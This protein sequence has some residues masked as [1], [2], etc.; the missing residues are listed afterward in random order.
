MSNR[1]YFFAGGGT[2][3]HIYP[4]LATAQQLREIDP[5]GE[6]HFFCS[7]RP[8]DSQ[9]LSKTDFAF[10]PL[11]AKGF[12]VRP[13]QLIAFLNSIRKSRAIVKPI[14]TQTTDNTVVIGVGGFASAPVVLTANKLGLPV[15]MI[16]V[17]I[18]PGKANKF[19]ARYASKIF[20]QFDDTAKHFGK[21]SP[22]VETTGCPLRK[23]FANPNPDKVYDDLKLDRSKRTLL[24]TGAST[25]AQN[26]NDAILTILPALNEF[27][28]NW[29]IV[30]LTGKANFQSVTNAYQTKRCQ[31]PFILDYYDNM[32]DL[33]AA[34]DILIGRAGAVSIAEFAASA[35]PAI[36]LPY[37]YHKDKHQYLNAQQLVNAG[38]A[39]IVDD[40]PGNKQKTAQML[41]TQLRE[42]MASDAK[43]KAMAKAASSVHRIDAASCIACKLADLKI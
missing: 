35:T 11:P 19:L 4:A 29:Q 37:P 34:A 2:G 18:V 8:I 14:L 15:A 17:D 43:R 42:L 32:W 10:T 20:V 28:E 40:L 27:A 13:A 3:G 23:G 1:R 39:V 21:N 33:Y 5:E 41:L 16:N 12:S 38:A 6:I 25:G 31:E 7:D 26:I 9:I 36:C 22:K 24:I 30:H